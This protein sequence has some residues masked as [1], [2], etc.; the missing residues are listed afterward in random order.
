MTQKELKM[1]QKFKFMFFTENFR[2]PKFST[3]LNNVWLKYASLKNIIGSEKY[4]IW[5]Y[6][7]G[8]IVFN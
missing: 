4:D 6:F 5:T 1:S 3:N 2:L 7:I 8:K